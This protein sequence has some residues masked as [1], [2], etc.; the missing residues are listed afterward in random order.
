M[1][2][3]V[4]LQDTLGDQYPA[5][6]SAAEELAELIAAEIVSRKDEAGGLTQLQFEWD[7]GIVSA[8]GAYVDDRGK[9][10]GNAQ[11]DKRTSPPP[12]IPD[13]EADPSR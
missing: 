3:K 12:E 4:Q 6:F 9:R 8:N 7:E 10:V 11:T 2:G 1:I 13:P 5:I